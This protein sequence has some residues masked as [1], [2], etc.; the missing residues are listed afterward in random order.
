MRRFRR[1]ACW[2]DTRSRP[3]AI[4]V[5]AGNGPFPAAAQSSQRLALTELRP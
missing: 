4:V 3:V 1:L 2:L 5:V